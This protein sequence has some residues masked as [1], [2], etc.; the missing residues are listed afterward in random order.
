MQV[1][2]LGPGLAFRYSPHLPASRPTNFDTPEYA[3][4]VASGLQHHA[5]RSH[6]AMRPLP[7]RSRGCCATG[8]RGC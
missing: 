8:C 4:I 5:A 1:P 3:N 7:R 6:G 2:S